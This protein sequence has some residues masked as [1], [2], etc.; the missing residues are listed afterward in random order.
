MAL[1]TVSAYL[2]AFSE[3]RGTRVVKIKKQETT[4]E[5]HSVHRYR[6]EHCILDVEFITGEN[7]CTRNG[8]ERL[9][10]FW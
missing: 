6:D 8:D 3:T 9:L 4:R 5:N 10:R 1:E 2:Q 7:T